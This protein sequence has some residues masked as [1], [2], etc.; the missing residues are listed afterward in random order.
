MYIQV[1]KSKI[2]RVRVTQANLN[3]VGSITIDRTLMEAVGI[4]PG[5]RVQVVPCNNV[6]RL[7]TYVTAG[8][9]DSA[10]ICLNGPAA[11]LLQ[12]NNTVIIMSYALMDYDEAR[13]FQPKII[14]PDSDTNRL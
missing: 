14:F 8:E 12:P 10:V 7:A 3:Y 5:E 4:L 13:T 2:H 11:R 6:N 9:P 1:L